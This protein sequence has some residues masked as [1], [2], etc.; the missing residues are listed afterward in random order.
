MFCMR[1][2]QQT[3]QWV[4]LLQLAT[5]LKINTKNNGR[6]KIRAQEIIRTC[7]NSCAC[8]NRLQLPPFSL[9]C[10]N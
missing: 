10:I 6:K 7:I 8:T 1:W 2:M 4:P 5:T 9:L 3:K